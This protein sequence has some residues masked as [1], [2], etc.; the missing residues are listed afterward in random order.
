[1]KATRAARHSALREVSGHSDEAPMMESNKADPINYGG[2]QD[3]DDT[4]EVE[5][6]QL[7]YHEPR[8]DNDAISVYLMP[9]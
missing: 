7:D 3:E 1:M 4:A 9:E 8:T 2:L 5:N 6:A